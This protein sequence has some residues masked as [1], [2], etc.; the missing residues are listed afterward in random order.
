MSKF[1]PKTK[2]ITDPH[3]IVDRR[4]ITIK[5]RLKKAGYPTRLGSPNS[6]FVKLEHKVITQWKPIGSPGMSV[7]EWEML[8]NTSARVLEDLDHCQHGWKYAL[9]GGMSSMREYFY[10]HQVLFQDKSEALMFKLRMR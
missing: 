6:A 7:A 10:A 8:T 3:A 9:W 2:V 5:D 4:L 1:K